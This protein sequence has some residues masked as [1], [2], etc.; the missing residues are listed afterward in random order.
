MSECHV[1]S[2]LG[3]VGSRFWRRVLTRAWPMVISAGGMLGPGFG[4]E[5]LVL[6]KLGV[7]QWVCGISP[8]TC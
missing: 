1:G 3:R 5:H 2:W 7:S 8:E 6:E 4:G